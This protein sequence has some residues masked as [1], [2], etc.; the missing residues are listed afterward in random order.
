VLDTLADRVLS[1]PEPPREIITDDG[2]VSGAVYFALRKHT[3]GYE[4][5]AKRRKKFRRD[6]MAIGARS[7]SSVGDRLAFGAIPDRARIAAEWVVE[8]NAGRHDRG[9]RAD[10]I[11]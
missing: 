8:R 11:Q 1:R 6:A 3:A 4:W 2:Y 10:T 9:K 7:R 5:H